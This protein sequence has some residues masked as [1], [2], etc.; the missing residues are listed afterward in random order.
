MAHPKDSWEYLETIVFQMETRWNL[1]EG[2]EGRKERKED[3][4]VETGKGY[5]KAVK[6]YREKLAHTLS[7]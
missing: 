2:R 7:A 3:G 5:Q 4:K 6:T 1:K